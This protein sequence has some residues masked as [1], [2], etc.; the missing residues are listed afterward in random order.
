M[1]SYT[2]GC[3]KRALNHILVSILR[4]F[5]GFPR[6][7]WNPVITYPGFL[8]KKWIPFIQKNAFLHI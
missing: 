2:V 5:G 6:K 4:R 7:N 1:F 8:S 3:K